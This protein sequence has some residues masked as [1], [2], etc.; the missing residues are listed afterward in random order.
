MG[1]MKNDFKKRYIFTAMKMI[2]ANSSIQKKPGNP[3]MPPEVKSL[4]KNNDILP[5]AEH[6]GI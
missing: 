6:R 3:G 2:M 4:V 1:C 5:D